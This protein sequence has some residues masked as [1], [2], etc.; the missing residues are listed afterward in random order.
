MTGDVVWKLSAAL[1][2]HVIVSVCSTKLH[3]GK[4]YPALGIIILYLFISIYFLFVSCF[5]AISVTVGLL[6]K[7]EV[8]S[9]YSRVTNAYRSETLHL[10]RKRA[11]HAKESGSSI[12]SL[13]ASLYCL[14]LLFPHPSGCDKPLS[15]LTAEHR[16]PTSSVTRSSRDFFPIPKFLKVESVNFLSSF[17]TCPYLAITIPGIVDEQEMSGA[18]TRTSSKVC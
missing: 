8:A 4:S 9:R 14:F 18:L 1:L 7:A 16:N 6:C 5:K 11:L 12:T 17:Q 15:E 2:L 3:K 13:S 10:L